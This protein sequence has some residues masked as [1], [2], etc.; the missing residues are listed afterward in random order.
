MKGI[1]VKEI[2]KA[3]EKSGVSRI[4]PDAVNKLKK[5]KKKYESKDDEKGAE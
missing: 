5:S 4:S 2:I 3:M 1:T